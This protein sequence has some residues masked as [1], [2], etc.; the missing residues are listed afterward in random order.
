VSLLEQGW[1]PKIRIAEPTQALKSISRDQSLRWLVDLA[2][3]TT[4]SAVDVQRMYLQEA[5]CALAGS[6]PDA[7][8]TLAEWRHVLD[9]LDRDIMLARDRVDWVAKRGLLEQYME[10]EGIGWDDPFMQ[11]LDLAYHDVDPEQGLYYGLLDAGEM[12]QLV[13]DRRIETAMTCAPADTRAYLRGL[14]VKRF[15]K[16]I[17]SI[18]WNGVSFEHG[19]ED[20]VFDMNSL[21]Q[22]NVQLL[23]EEMANAVTLEDAIAIIEQKP[24]AKSPNA[25]DTRP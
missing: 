19:D 6:T 15:S 2:D 25:D 24:H 17:H 13:T 4:A 7:D 9:D 8:W 11:S 5:Q 23:N 16:S 1:E 22:P 21:V 12:R 10:T 20:F 3:G 18:G 14:F